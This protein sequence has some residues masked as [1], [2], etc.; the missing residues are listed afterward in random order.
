MEGICMEQIRKKIQWVGDL[1][2]SVEPVYLWCY[3]ENGHPLAS[4][5]PEGLI[6]DEVFDLRDWRKCMLRHFSNSCDPYLMGSHFG[7]LWMCVLDKASAQKRIYVMGPVTTA[8]ISQRQFQIGLEHVKQKYTGPRSFEE[9]VK[10]LEHAPVISP[11]M[12]QRYIIMLHYAINREKVPIDS[13]NFNSS[14]DET[15]HKQ[16][17]KTKDR[18]KN[19]RAEQALLHAVRT[20]DINYTRML[21]AAQ[22]VGKGIVVTSSDPLRSMKN[23]LIIFT[24]LCTRAGIEGGLSPEEAYSL[25]DRYIQEAENSRSA[26][27]LTACSH[28]MLDDFVQRVHRKRSNPKLSSQIQNCCDYIEL[29]C[30]EKLRIRDLAQNAGYTEYYLSKRFKQE[31][32][33]TINDY[34][35]F[36]KIERAKMLLCTTD[37]DIGD[38]SEQLCF[39]SRGYFGE[40]FAQVVGITPTKYRK[41]NQKR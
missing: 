29:H 10:S 9:L 35:K 25:G 7:V 22:S 34:I 33:I 30:E 18:H 26:A 12:I 23:T 28:T 8:T 31:M 11:N 16:W 19:Y 2:Q 4:N 13:I 1:F 41:E 40:V 17:Q 27:E 14:K 3:D 6:P 5:C 21:S 37:M 24:T 15:I 32:G 39:S 36:T 38:I 20:G